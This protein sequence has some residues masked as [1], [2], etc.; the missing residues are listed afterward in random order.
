[1]QIQ[2]AIVTAGAMS[3]QPVD[4]LGLPPRI[5]ARIDVA[6][7]HV[8]E[9]QNICEKLMSAKVRIIPASVTGQLA[10]VRAFEAA[11]PRRLSLMT[12]SAVTE[13]KTPCMRPNTR[14]LSVSP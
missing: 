4:P 6:W 2:V 14:K 3:D 10:P 13:T 9:C 7:L 5:C 11:C 12:M 1:M 8:G